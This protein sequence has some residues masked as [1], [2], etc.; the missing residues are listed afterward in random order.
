MAKRIQHQQEA[1]LPRKRMFLLLG[2][3]MILTTA[4]IGTSSLAW[5]AVGNTTYVQNINVGYI[6]DEFHMDIIKGGKL[7]N[8]P[9]ST[10]SFDDKLVFTPVSTMHLDRWYSVE[11]SDPSIDSPEFLCGNYATA[12]YS[13][14]KDLATADKEYYSFELILSCNQDCYVYLDPSSS[15]TVNH[16]ANF[17]VAQAEASAQ[18]RHATE[19]ELEARAY[20]LDQSVNASR[21]S[22]FSNMGYNIVDPNKEEGKDVVLAGPLDVYHTDGY[23]DYDPDTLKET[24]YGE[25][26]PTILDEIEYELVTDKNPA[27]DGENAFEASLKQGTYCFDWEKTLEEFSDRIAHE[28]SYSIAEFGFYN[29][30]SDIHGGSHLKGKSHPICFIPAGKEERVVMSFYVEGWDLDCINASASASFQ[31]DLSFDGFY[32]QE[33]M[34]GTPS[35][36]IVK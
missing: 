13:Y 21:I 11:E 3:M 5:F 1:V 29:D 34:A 27:G 25:Y 12:N 36:V 24:I 19:E 6:G 10:Y 16:D 26:D 35:R 31:F 15:V 17:L 20:E 33:G 14:E 7:Y 23:F 32:A 22:F 30:T 18:G 4:S 9:K 28:Q 8:N 2:A